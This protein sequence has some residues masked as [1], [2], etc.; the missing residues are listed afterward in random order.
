MKI[1]VTGVAGLLGSHIS[2]VL[3]IAGHEVI[4]VDNFIGGYKDN[5]PRNISFYQADCLSYGDMKEL[6]TGCEVVVHCAATAYEGLSVFSPHLVTQNIFGATTGVLSAALANKVRR[7][8]YLSSMARYG[9]QQTP[10]TEDMP[11]KPQDPYGIAKVAAEN[12]VRN[13][14]NTHGMDW[15]IVV[16]HNIIGPR[17]LYT[18]PFRNVASI[19][20][21]RCLQGKPPIIYGDGRQ[22]RCFSFVGDVLEPLQKLIIG[23]IRGETLNVGPDEEF[24][25]INDLAKL[26]MKLTGFE[27]AVIHM[28]G[29]PQEVKEATCSADKARRLLGYKT[30]TTLEQGI[31][32][33]VDYVK[34]RGTQPFDYHLPLEFTT[35]KT[36]ETWTKR[37]L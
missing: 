28:P 16:P 37:L 1:F 8:I 7:F 31:Q 11:T 18:D 20:V 21:N 6:M 23:D 9:S 14:C 32:S 27:G 30:S 33:I 36:P 34:T 19:M 13:L 24:V 5:I 10:F 35:D 26:V 4:G 17:Q 22:K 15:N 3:T 29:R 25:E 2:E 12:I